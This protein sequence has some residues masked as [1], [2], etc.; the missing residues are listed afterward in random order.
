VSVW[1]GEESLDVCESVGR[2][3]SES[4]RVVAGVLMGVERPV[5]AAFV[6][7]GGVVVV[8]EL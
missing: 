3:L 5:F 6:A 1:E 2:K 4:D 7:V 8:V